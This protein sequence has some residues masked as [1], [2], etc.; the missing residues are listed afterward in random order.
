MFAP[1]GGGVFHRMT[2]AHLR[3]NEAAIRGYAATVTA[4]ALAVFVVFAS[5]HL[6]HPLSMGLWFHFR[7][8]EKL[9][10]A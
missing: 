8:N 5:F 7:Q 2:F 1:C 6:D 9:L 4:G 10:A 3:A